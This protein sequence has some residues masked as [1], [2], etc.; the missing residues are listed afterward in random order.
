MNTKNIF[1]PEFV[2]GKELI[3]SSHYGLSCI[4]V[5]YYADD[6]EAEAQLFDPNFID[7]AN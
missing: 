4:E 6:L 5:S 7:V 1:Y 3:E 2:A